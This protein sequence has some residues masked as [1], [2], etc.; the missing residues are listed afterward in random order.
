MR[1]SGLR[2]ATGATGMRGSTGATG[3]P[4]SRRK[5]HAGCPGRPEMLFSSIYS[6]PDV[7]QKQQV[8]LSA[9]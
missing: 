1:A 7:S 5:R 4:A 8:P 2:G 3:Q 9:D 6:V